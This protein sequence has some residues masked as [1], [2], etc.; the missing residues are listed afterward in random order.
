MARQVGF[1]FVVCFLFDATILRTLLSLPICCSYWWPPMISALI[2]DYTLLDSWLRTTE[3]SA[4]AKH[5]LDFRK[6]CFYT[7]CANILGIEE[8]YVVT[9]SGNEF[10]SEE[11]EALIT[12]VISFE[13]NDEDA[14]HSDQLECPHR[15][16]SRVSSAYQVD[17]LPDW[18]LFSVPESRCSDLKLESSLE[19]DMSTYHIHH[20]FCEGQIVLA[21]RPLP[22]SQGLEM[23]DNESKLLYCQ[24]SDGARGL[25]YYVCVILEVQDAA[26]VSEEKTEAS[27]CSE[28][29]VDPPPRDLHLHVYDGVRK[30]DVPANV[31]RATEDTGCGGTSACSWTLRELD[32]FL[33]GLKK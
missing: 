14:A 20:Q 27:S 28:N 16:A 7:L 15:G 21:P 8:E 24:R 6:L 4:I 1:I 23:Q 3:K 11:V 32:V 29:S 25:K 17:V 31:C 19:V 18:Q 22:V 26:N 33:S 5:I 2:M 30:W 13:L 12:A 10:C 9:E